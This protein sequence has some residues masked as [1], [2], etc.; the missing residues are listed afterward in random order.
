MKLFLDTNVWIDLLAE[1]QPH[2]F[3]AATL[4]TFAEEGKCRIV[5][6]SLSMVNSQFVCCERGK[7]PLSLWKLKVKSLS[8]LFEVCAIDSSDIYD[9]I[10]SDWTDYEDGV[11]YFA[12]KKSDCDVIVTRNPRDFIFSDMEVLTPDEAILKLNS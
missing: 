2:Y 5:V 1:H 8:D 10:Q 4:F 7:M 11:Q 3:P 9:S 6:S 12:A